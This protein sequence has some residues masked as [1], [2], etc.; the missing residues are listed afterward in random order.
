MPDLQA[1][2]EQNQRDLVVLA[3]NVEGSSTDEARRLSTDFRDELGLTFPIVLDTPDGDV[4]SQYKLKG[5]PDTFLV[6]S[7]GVVRSIAIGPMNEDTI[8]KKLRE[9]R[10]GS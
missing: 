8:R 10:E 9:I 6:D 2:Y 7:S 3:V 5:L 4:Y 1:V